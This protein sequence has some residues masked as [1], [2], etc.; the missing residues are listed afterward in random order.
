MLITQR[1]KLPVAMDH[2]LQNFKF[3]YLLSQ[4]C[5][6]LAHKTAEFFLS[7]FVFFS[8]SFSCGDTLVLRG[9]VE[10]GQSPHR[11]FLAWLRWTAAGRNFGN[12][13]ATS[14]RQRDAVRGGTAGLAPLLPKHFPPHLYACT[15]HRSR[16]GYINTVANEKPF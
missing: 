8:N 15:S 10:A 12:S 7:V 5:S 16:P 1:Y 14:T 9:Y 13:K 11:R 3:Q 6:S 2:H 4:A